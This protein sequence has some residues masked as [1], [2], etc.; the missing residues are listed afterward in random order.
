[1]E[2][3]FGLQHAASRL[4]RHYGE[5]LAQRGGTATLRRNI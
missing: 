2:Q 5:T 4:I 3:T 1:M